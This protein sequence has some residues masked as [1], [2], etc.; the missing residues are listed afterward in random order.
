[1]KIKHLNDIPGFSWVAT[2]NNN[3][4]FGKVSIC[5]ESF[6]LKGCHEKNG[7][8]PQ[9]GYIVDKLNANTK[10]GENKMEKHTTFMGI[11][12]TSNNLKHRN[13]MQTKAE[14]GDLTP[15]GYWHGLRATWNNM[16]DEE[17]TEELK[18]I[19]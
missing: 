8:W 18:K 11:T 5:H 2:G 9:I 13:E 3:D 17:K 4:G 6:W 7:M 1:M 19:Y 12:T 10:Q 16:D 14:A 15:L